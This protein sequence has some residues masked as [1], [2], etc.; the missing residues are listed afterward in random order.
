MQI[1][2]QNLWLYKIVMVLILHLI[3]SHNVCLFSILTVFCI[4][5]IVSLMTLTY[6]GLPKRVLLNFQ[7]PFSGLNW[8]TI[9][10]T[11][12]ILSI[13]TIYHK[14]H[15]RINEFLNNNTSKYISMHCFITLLFSIAQIDI[16]LLTF[17]LWVIYL[18]VN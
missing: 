15:H 5:W 12:S 13:Y 16:I 6:S 18:T 8:R 7:N 17:T 4:F 14:I 2:L 11:V 9:Y 1:S 10:L 3:Y